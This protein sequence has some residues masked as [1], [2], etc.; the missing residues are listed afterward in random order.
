MKENNNYNYKQLDNKLI[1]NGFNKDNLIK[2]FK[3]F[4]IEHSDLLQK[5]NYNKNQNHMY[6]NNA[7]Q[8]MNNDK[9]IGKSLFEHALLSP[10]ICSP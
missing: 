10:D 3:L 7:F 2:K 4:T 8:H 1:E 9:V 6:I 5:W